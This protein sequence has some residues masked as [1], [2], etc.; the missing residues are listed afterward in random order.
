MSLVC[1]NK[2]RIGAL[3]SRQ[4]TNSLRAF[5]TLSPPTKPSDEKKNDSRAALAIASKAKWNAT[6]A[7]ASKFVAQSRSMSTTPDFRD[8]KPTLEY[9][10]KLPKTFASMTNEQILTFAEMGIP[11]ACRECIVRDVMVVDQIEYDEALKV[12]KQIAQVN[13]E[14]MKIASLPFYVGFGSS[15]TAA[16][17][18]IPL[19]FHLPSVDWF[20]HNFVTAELPPV[21][22]LETWLEVGSASW[23]WMEPV[24]GQISF[25]LLCMQFARSQ[26]QNL[27]LRPYYRWQLERRA[28]RLVQLYPQYDAEFLKLYS[29]CDQLAEA[30]E[31]SE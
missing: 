20:N 5:Q 14:G 15:V 3:S 31:M 1:A 29:K 10:K 6:Y 11:E 2:L 27:G 24:L 12:F 9:A 30:H 13:R 7:I 25:F 28:S 19:V 26:L 18:S 23:G 8:G 22:D 16:Y 17:L 21:E 4:L